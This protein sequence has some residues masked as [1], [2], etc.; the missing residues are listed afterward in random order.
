MVARGTVRVGGLLLGCVI[1][2]DMVYVSVLAIGAVSVLLSLVSRFDTDPLAA[3]ESDEAVR[4][5]VP[6]GIG[7]S[8]VVDGAMVVELGWKG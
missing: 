6:S 3:G 1:G 5:V 2:V 8:W 7:D 4:H